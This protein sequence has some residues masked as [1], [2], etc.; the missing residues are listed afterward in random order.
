MGIG[1]SCTP[2]DAGRLLGRITAYDNGMR[3]RPYTCFTLLRFTLGAYYL[4]Y[5][6]LGTLLCPPL[7]SIYIQTH[8]YLLMFEYRTSAP[9]YPRS[10]GL[11]TNLGKVRYCLCVSFSLIHCRE[12]LKCT[13]QVPTIPL[14]YLRY[15]GY[16]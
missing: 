4:Q 7:G 3:S 8:T 13:C 5:D 10:L 1:A 9:R 12:D 15:L 11:G 6:Y 16:L 2:G 14:P